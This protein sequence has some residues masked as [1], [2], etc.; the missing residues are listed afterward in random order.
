MGGECSTPGQASAGS[1]AGHGSRARH[2]ELCRVGHR[3]AA[4]GVGV[5][6]TGQGRDMPELM[7]PAGATSPR[8]ARAFVASWLASW[9]LERLRDRAELAT[10][11]LVTNALEHTSSDVGVLIEVH[12]NEVRIAITDSHTSMPVTRHVVSETAEGGR[13]LRIVSSI[14]DSWWTERVEGNGKTVWCAFALS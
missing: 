6:G 14:T 2:R 7:L 5:R 12:P 1:W 9:G 4:R 13:G 3:S 10:S 11:E 8:A